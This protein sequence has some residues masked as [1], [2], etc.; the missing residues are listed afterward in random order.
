M[1]DD[2]N[3]DRTLDVVTFMEQQNETIYD[4]RPPEDHYETEISWKPKFPYPKRFNNYDAW[5]AEFYGRNV[6]GENKYLTG[7][8]ARFAEKAAIYLLL[9]RYG[10][11]K[12]VDLNLAAAID[13][14]LKFENEVRKLTYDLEAYYKDETYN[15]DVK[16]RSNPSSLDLCI[17]PAKIHPSEHLLFVRIHNGLTDPKWEQVGY[18]TPEMFQMMFGNQ[19]INRLVYVP[20]YFAFNNTFDSYL[21]YSKIKN[22]ATV[23]LMMFDI[24]SGRKTSLSR[25][26]E[27]ALDEYKAYSNNF[28]LEYW[29]DLFRFTIRKAG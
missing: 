22:P 17:N 2:E 10:F 15:F 11:D 18:I 5:L 12:V 29:N 7:V 3:D 19:I 4:E 26:E 28:D 27:Y 25:K 6:A 16:S 20:G 14:K 21:E 24:Q 9:K 13:H 8:H 23:P 1:F